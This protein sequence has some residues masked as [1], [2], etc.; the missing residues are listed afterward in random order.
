LDQLPRTP[1]PFFFFCPVIIRFSFLPSAVRSAT[2]QA[3]EAPVWNL[4]ELQDGQ[5]A[6]AMQASSPSQLIRFDNH[7]ASHSLYFT[8]EN[9]GLGRRY[10]LCW[11]AKCSRAKYA[12]CICGSVAAG[13][14]RWH[15]V[16]GATNYAHIQT[17]KALPPR[18][19]LRS[20]EDPVKMVR[21]LQA[22]KNVH[23][24][25]GEGTMLRRLVAIR[26]DPKGYNPQNEQY[27]LGP[28][29]EKTLGS[30]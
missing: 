5:S 10:R 25:T 19:S 28:S 20:Q 9:R 3:E 11:R 13:M 21:A 30:A 2:G 15:G 4:R 29:Y 12:E 24:N 1:I 8:T 23:G 18:A 27:F 6:K 22:M 14:G 7:C 16:V 17:T 26:V